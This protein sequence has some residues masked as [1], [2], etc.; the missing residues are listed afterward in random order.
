MLDLYRPTHI[1]SHLSSKF[2]TMNNVFETTCQ[3]IENSEFKQHSYDLINLQCD[4]ADSLWKSNIELRK[5]SN[6]F[7]LLLKLESCTDWLLLTLLILLL[8]L[9]TTS[10]CLRRISKLFCL[11]HYLIQ[12]RGRGLPSIA[13]FQ[14]RNRLRHSLNKLFL[15]L[16]LRMRVI[17]I[18]TL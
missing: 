7:Q 2:N 13:R 6:L 12:D 18:G 8:L 1:T 5:I 15:I 17:S 4:H 10:T 9:D 11:L 3:P 14:F 16:D